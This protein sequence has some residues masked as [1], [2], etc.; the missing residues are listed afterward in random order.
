MKI[1][2]FLTPFILL[3]PASIY[4][5]IRTW[6]GDFSEHNL[7]PGRSPLFISIAFTMLIADLFLKYLVGKGR[8]GVVW[9]IELIL[10]AILAIMI[11]PK[12]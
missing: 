2:K 1:L 7:P 12:F 3:F 10:V 6:L 8:V 11:V 4:L 5:A 9:I